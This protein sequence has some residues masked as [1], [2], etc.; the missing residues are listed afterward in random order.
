MT[1]VENQCWPHLFISFHIQE[2]NR[3]A[4][5]GL[6]NV[7]IESSAAGAGKY[8]EIDGDAGA[9]TVH[10][11]SGGADRSRGDDDLAKYRRG[12]GG[13][14]GVAAIDRGDGMGAGGE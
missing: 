10:R 3:I 6:G 7:D 2:D 5:T 12:A 4:I 9:R 14:C 11:Q 1:G 13:K 8:C